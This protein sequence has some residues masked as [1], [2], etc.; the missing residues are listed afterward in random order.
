MGKY[1]YVSSAHLFDLSYLP[2]V[3]KVTLICV[4]LVSH[5]ERRILWYSMI[6]TLWRIL[7]GKMPSSV[8][9]TTLGNTLMLIVVRL[10]LGRPD[11]GPFSLITGVK[12][13]KSPFFLTL[14]KWFIGDFS[15]LVGLVDD[16]NASWR[17]NRRVFEN[18]FK[19]SFDSSF[20]CKNLVLEL[21]ALLIF[22]RQ[23]KQS[24]V[25]LRD[26]FSKY[27][28]KYF[29]SFIFGKQ[30]LVAHSIFDA[31]L[32]VN[33]SILSLYPSWF[34]KIAYKI[35]DIFNHYRIYINFIKIFRYIYF[36]LEQV[37][38]CCFVFYLEVRVRTT[39][40]QLAMN[41]PFA[42]LSMDTFW[43]WKPKSPTQCSPP[44]QVCPD[45]RL[46]LFPRN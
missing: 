43:S 30:F 28:R 45:V 27:V 8:C 10:K 21:K 6:G 23:S 39:T 37:I 22:L 26:S 33:I 46:H 19:G 44:C 34:G 5:S 36:V 29:Y 42:T 32:F 1:L 11:E 14:S 3:L 15:P 9:W 16:N 12:S 17:E 24:P 31:S 13:K 25:N 7:C 38:I 35:F 20:I 4:W 18:I 40:K 41:P 2:N